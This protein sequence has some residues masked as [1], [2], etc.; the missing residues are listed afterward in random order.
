MKPLIFL[1]GLL[2][3]ITVFGGNF[4]PGN[5]NTGGWS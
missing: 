3:N 4:N 5:G 2:F 1:M